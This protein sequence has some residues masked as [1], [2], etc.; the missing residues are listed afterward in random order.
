MGKNNKSPKMPSGTWVTRELY[1]SKAFLA[2]RGVAPQALVIFLGKRDMRRI[3]FG[4][5]TDWVC[6]NRDEIHFTYIEAEKKCGITKAR[7]SRALD[8]LLAKGFIQVAHKGGA[9]QKDMSVYALSDGW[10]LWKNGKIIG[11]RKK[12]PVARGFCKPN[13]KKSTLKVVP[14]TSTESA[15]PTP[16]LVQQKRILQIEGERPIYAVKIGTCS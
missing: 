9:W 13:K 2:L 6:T 11:S 3:K 5:R 14:S 12:E 10:R 7:F 16:C 8:E 15:P 4:K 1:T